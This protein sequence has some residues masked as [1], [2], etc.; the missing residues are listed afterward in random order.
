MIS[1]ITPTLRG[2]QGSFEQDEDESNALLPLHAGLDQ[3]AVPKDRF[4]CTVRERQSIVDVT[5]VQMTRHPQSSGVCMCCL[6]MKGMLFFQQV[7]K[8]LYTM[9]PDTFRIDLLIDKTTKRSMEDDQPDIC[10]MRWTCCGI[11]WQG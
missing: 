3:S 10:R 4:M 5:A 2:K 7:Q 6:S 11:D 8:A 1:F 9:L